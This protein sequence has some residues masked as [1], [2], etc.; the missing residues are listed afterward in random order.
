MVSRTL[1]I[2]I[3]VLP[4]M[5]KEISGESVGSIESVLQTVCSVN[6]CKLHDTYV[7]HDHVHILLEANDE[8][9]ALRVIPDAIDA[10][11]QAI[12]T[13]DADFQ[14]QEGVHVTL[15]P[16]WH[17]Q[18]LGSFVRDQF[19]FHETN[20]V[21]D[22]LNQIFRPGLIGETDITAEVVSPNAN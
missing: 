19:R 8:E 3:M 14:F 12:N 6:K 5:G 4:V 16:P 21:E 9:G 17:I 18:V 15:V 20:S 7:A 11:K 22:E 13:I 10:M 2:H 1:G